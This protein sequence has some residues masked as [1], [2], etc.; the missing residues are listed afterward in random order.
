MALQDGL[1]EETEV[2]CNDSNAKSERLS[3]VTI[4]VTHNN[5]RKIG[6]TSM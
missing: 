1:I 6:S 4:F 3:W 2:L 5:L